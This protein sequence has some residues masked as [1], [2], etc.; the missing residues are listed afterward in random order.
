MSESTLLAV[1]IPSA[2][3]LAGI[4]INNHRLGDVNHR[5]IEMQSHLDHRLTAMERLFEEK[6]RRVE[7]VMDARLTRIEQELKLR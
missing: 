6:L 2:T 7:E 5:L 1:V 4:L 3:V